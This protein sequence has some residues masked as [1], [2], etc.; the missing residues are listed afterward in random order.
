V[1][2]L[3]LQHI[4][5]F[6]EPFFFLIRDGEALSEIKLRIQKRLQ[7]PDEQFLKVLVSTFAI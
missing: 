1:T 4:Q 3:Y 6:G 2:T 5:Y 7:V